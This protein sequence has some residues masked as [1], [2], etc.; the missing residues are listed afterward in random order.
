MIT[1]T[2]CGSIQ[3]PW[4]RN[5]PH[6]LPVCST[7]VHCHWKVCCNGTWLHG[8]GYHRLC[9]ALGIMR[10]HLVCRV[11]MSC[12]CATH[13]CITVGPL[14]LQSSSLTAW[15]PSNP[16]AEVWWDTNLL[17]LARAIQHLDALCV[18]IS[19]HVPHY[20]CCRY[21][22]FKQITFIENSCFGKTIC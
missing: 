8:T 16:R 17:V 20:G 9:M 18:Y 2:S 4:K 1:A 15:P 5:G 14:G 11:N 6:V 19:V 13:K 22:G 21:V 7:Q 3:P 10:L 12:Q